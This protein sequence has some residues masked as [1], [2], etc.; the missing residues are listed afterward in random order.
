MIVTFWRS[1][2][3]V[4]PAALEVDRASPASRLGAGRI[5]PQWEGRTAHKRTFVW[6]TLSTFEAVKGHAKRSPKAR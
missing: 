4:A 2:R 1:G 6:L 3:K 5:R